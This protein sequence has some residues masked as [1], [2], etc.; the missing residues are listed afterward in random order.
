MLITISFCWHL[1]TIM[2]FLLIELALVSRLYSCSRS[3]SN[4]CD[5]LMS[6]DDQLGTF[7]ARNKSEDQKYFTMLGQEDEDD[8]IFDRSK[9]L[10]DL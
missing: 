2:V 7:N 6:I 8:E 10:P 4:L 5:Q 9:L 1:M 3:I